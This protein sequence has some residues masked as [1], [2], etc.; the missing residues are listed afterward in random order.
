MAIGRAHH[1][2]FGMLV[3]ETGDAAGPFALD[4]GSTFQ[5]KAEFEKEID[6]RVEIFDRDSD[7][8]HTVERHSIDPLNNRCNLHALNE[9]SKEDELPGAM[10][11][12]KMSFAA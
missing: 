3:A 8:V 10:P 12:G 11:V 7:I 6:C 1:G 5:F 4:H 9:P 2:D